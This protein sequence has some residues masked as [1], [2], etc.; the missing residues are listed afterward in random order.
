MVKT[1][2]GDHLAHHLP[3]AAL[4]AR[5]RAFLGSLLLRFPSFPWW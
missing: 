2:A 4:L 1:R 3:D 5:F